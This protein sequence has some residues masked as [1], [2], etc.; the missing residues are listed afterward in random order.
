[1]SYC[2]CKVN[3]YGASLAMIDYVDVVLVD[4][5]QLFQREWVLRVLDVP[6][7]IYTDQHHNL[8]A[9]P[10]HHRPQEHQSPPHKPLKQAPSQG[11]RSG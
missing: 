10:T 8:H 7:D 5:A 4:H 3:D 2:W 6:D 11:T 1:M 9:H